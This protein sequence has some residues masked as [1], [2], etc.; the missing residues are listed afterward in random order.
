MVRVGPVS[1]VGDDDPRA[2]A[3]VGHPVR[4]ELERHVGDD[5]GREEPVEVRGVQ[6]V[7]DVGHADR[8]AALET[9]H[10]I[11]DAQARERIPCLADGRRRHAGSGMPAG[12]GRSGPSPMVAVAASVTVGGIS[13]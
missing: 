12:A 1:P 11:D 13:E 10:E 2:V 9:R 5:R 6:P 7:G 4:L 3:V 8:A